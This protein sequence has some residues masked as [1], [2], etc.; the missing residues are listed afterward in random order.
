[1]IDL[2]DVDEGHVAQRQVTLEKCVARI[3]L[4]RRQRRDIDAAIGEL[5]RFVATLSEADGAIHP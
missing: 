2:Y 5:E 4:L 3:D 1:M